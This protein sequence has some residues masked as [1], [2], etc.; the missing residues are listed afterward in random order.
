MM[1]KFKLFIDEQKEQ[2]WLNDMSAQGWHFT[3]FTP[4]LFRYTFEFDENNQYCYQ[5]DLLEKD[6]KD[7]I[8]FVESTGATLIYKNFAWAY[9]R[10]HSSKGKF[11]LYTDR[12][13]KISYLNKLLSFYSL[14]CIVNAFAF[15]ISLPD[16]SQYN[17]PRASLVILNAIFAILFA[18]L[19]WKIKDR[20]KRVKYQ[21]ELF[22]L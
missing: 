12:A 20:K 9:F 2:Q 10:K 5:I 13:S 7:Y 16:F 17:L 15:L 3:K 4:G 11:E 6:K 14:I 8:E 1:Q 22:E 21:Q 18:A 19:A